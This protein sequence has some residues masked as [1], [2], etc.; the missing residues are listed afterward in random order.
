VFEVI[1]GVLGEEQVEIRGPPTVGEVTVEGEE[2]VN[3]E[4]VVG[5]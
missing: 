4:S 2:L 1:R 3:G 5:G